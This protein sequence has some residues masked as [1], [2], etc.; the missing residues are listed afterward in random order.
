M[1]LKVLTLG[2]LLSL[3]GCSAVVPLRQYV[4]TLHD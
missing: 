3:A 4:L 2:L 1:V